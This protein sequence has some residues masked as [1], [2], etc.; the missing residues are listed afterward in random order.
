MKTTVIITGTEKSQ[1]PSVTVCGMAG[2][3]Q[4]VRAALGAANQWQGRVM[5]AMARLYSGLLDEEVSPQRAARLLN[6]QAAFVATLLC[7]GGPLWAAVPCAAWLVAAL[8]RC[9][10]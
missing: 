6:A 1:S 5:N 10:A 9:R 4:T 7:G 3:A 8:L 2:I